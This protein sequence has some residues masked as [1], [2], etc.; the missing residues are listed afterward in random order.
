MICRSCPKNSPE[1]NTY[2]YNLDQIATLQDAGFKFENEDFHMS[3]W[4][5][6]GFFRRIR[7]MKI[8]PNCPF[9]K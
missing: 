7:E 2:I 6:L 1:I 9:M 4:E 3:F 8:T 5:N